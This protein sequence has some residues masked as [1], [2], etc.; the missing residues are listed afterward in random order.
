VSRKL[1]SHPLLSQCRAIKASSTFG[2]GHCWPRWTRLQRYWLT[3]ILHVS[4]NSKNFSIK[5]RLNVLTC[6]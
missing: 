4:V 2:T 3:P 5:I 6:V 1:S